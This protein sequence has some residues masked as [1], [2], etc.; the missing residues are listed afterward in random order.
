MPVVVGAL[1]SS[2]LVLMIHRLPFSPA[3][4]ILGAGVVAAL[5]GGC[6]QD[7]TGGTQETRTSTVVE[8]TPPPADSGL[9]FD[10]LPEIPAGK[11]ATDACPYLDT[12]WLAETNGQRVVAVGVDQRFDTPACVFWS[13]PDQPQATVIVRHMDSVAAARQVVDWA[14][15]VDSTEPADHIP[16]FAGGRGRTEAGAVFAVSKDT[17]A[18]VVL[19]NQEQTIKAELIATEVIDTLGL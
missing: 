17:V 11:A 3:P 18:V 8:S 4:M 10:T 12:E 6:A 7:T 1:L 5:L 15:P 19:I 9:P 2:R 16:G 13:Y 14:A